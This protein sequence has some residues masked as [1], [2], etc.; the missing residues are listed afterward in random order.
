MDIRE[1]RAFIDTQ[2]RRWIHELA[3]RYGVSEGYPARVYRLP[4]L[5]R[6]WRTVVVGFVSEA[7]AKNAKSPLSDRW[8]NAVAV[9]MGLECPAP[10]ESEAYVDCT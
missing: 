9:D 5:P 8:P 2:V 10:I 1:A 7:E 4:D 3:I 6:I